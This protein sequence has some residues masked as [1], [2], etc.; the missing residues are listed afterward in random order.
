MT[1]RGRYRVAPELGTYTIAIRR[2]HHPRRTKVEMQ[3]AHFVGPTSYTWAQG[4][5]PSPI[6]REG[7][8]RD[9]RRDAD[10]YFVAVVSRLR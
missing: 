8:L 4:I 5:S 2:T 3:A 7:F 10:E 9:V 6:D 1:P